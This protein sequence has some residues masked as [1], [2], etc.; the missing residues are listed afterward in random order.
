VNTTTRAPKDFLLASW[1]SVHSSDI[2]EGEAS[3]V[4]AAEATA[5]TKTVEDSST[6]AQEEAEDTTV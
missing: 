4:T 2:T 1:Q 3:A 6:E 5:G